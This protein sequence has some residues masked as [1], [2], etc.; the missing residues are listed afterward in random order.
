MLNRKHVKQ[1]VRKYFNEASDGQIEILLEE[2]AR[3]IEVMTHVKIRELVNCERSK[4][5]TEQ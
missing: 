4:K 5:I 1:L 2:L 3:E